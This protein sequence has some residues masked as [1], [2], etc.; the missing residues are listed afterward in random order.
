M[1][2]LEAF[3]E[4]ASRIEQMRHNVSPGP[5]FTYDIYRRWLATSYKTRQH[6]EKLIGQTF[7]GL[8]GARLKHDG[9]PYIYFGS[10]HTHCAS[11]TVPKN[12]RL[13]MRGDP[14]IVSLPL[15]MIPY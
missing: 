11:P 1:L 13:S 12:A 6:A 10:R 8:V 7:C 15:A 3:K 5:A 4:W 9:E 14:S 2:R